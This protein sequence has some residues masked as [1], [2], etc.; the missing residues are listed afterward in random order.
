MS[1]ATNALARP[2]I[3]DELD[4]A[5]SRESSEKLTRFDGHS[6]TVRLDTGEAV[7]L[8][9]SAVMLLVELLGE[10]AEGNAITIVPQRAE[11]TVAQAADLL[12]VS[13]SF[14][15]DEVDAGAIPTRTVGGRQHVLLKDLMDY[16]HRLHVKR[17]AALD[18]LAALSQDLKLGY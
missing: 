5:L 12:N 7:T 16:K 11:L 14:L 10:M 17:K 2:V 15:Q 9:K 8:S 4:V 6:L 18:E 3:P 1:N 13:Y